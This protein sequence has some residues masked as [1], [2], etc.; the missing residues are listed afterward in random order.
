MTLMKRKPIPRFSAET[1]NGVTSLHLRVLYLQR[2]CNNEMLSMN[3]VY[4]HQILAA[5]H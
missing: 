1:L 4:G 3:S 2:H 5:Y